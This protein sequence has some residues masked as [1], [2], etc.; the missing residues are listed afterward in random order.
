MEKFI[1]VLFDTAKVKDGVLTTEQT[2][3]VYEDIQAAKDWGANS[4]RQHQNLA[5]SKAIGI[6]KLVE[7]GTND[8]PSVYF[9]KVVS[10]TPPTAVNGLSDDTQPEPSAPTEH[11]AE[12]FTN[13]FC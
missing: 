1:G 11:F 5:N 13:D 2:S 10:M 7:I 4:L 12:K 6:F 3:K 8:R 9:T